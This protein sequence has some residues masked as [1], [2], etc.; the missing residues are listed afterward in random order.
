MKTNKPLS[1]RR[2]LVP[3]DFSK[4][5]RQALRYAIPLAAQFGAATTLLHV[6][7]PV[8]YP[9]EMTIVVTNQKFALNASRRHLVELG[10]KFVPEKLRGKL[11]VRAGQPYF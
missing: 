7:E 4:N 3:I 8:I 11:F 6:V 9:T 10:E 5:A 2:I 1:L